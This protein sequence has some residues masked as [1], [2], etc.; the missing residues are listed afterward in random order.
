MFVLGAVLKL[1]FGAGFRLA[2]IETMLTNP[3]TFQLLVCID[4][5]HINKFF[6]HL[7]RV[8]S[9]HSFREQKFNKKFTNT[10][11]GVVFFENFAKTMS[12]RFSNCVVVSY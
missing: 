6:C 12:K 1:Q 7:G 8:S 5:M 9:S 2:A 4:L 11:V 3:N 10:S